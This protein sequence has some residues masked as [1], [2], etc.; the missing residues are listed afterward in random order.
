MK[1]FKVLLI[2]IYVLFAT[3]AW[4]VDSQ[5]LTFAWNP[6][7][8]LDLAGYKLYQSA[9]PGGPYTFVT[10]IPYVAGVM[11]YESLQVIHAPSGQKTTQYFVLTAYIS[12]AL[13]S[14]YS[15]EVSAEFDFRNAP[16]APIE[17]KI[18]VVPTP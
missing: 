7:P 5:V 4:C 8:E 10:A 3:N 6:N 2:L 1:K 14:S 17:F 9:A 15:N 13:E 16:S 11:E 12:A 18:K